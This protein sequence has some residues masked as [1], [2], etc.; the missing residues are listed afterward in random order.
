MLPHLLGEAL[1]LPLTGLGIRHGLSVAVP[2]S[3]RAGKVPPNVKA[4]GAQ[5]QLPLVPGLSKRALL[6]TWVKSREER[7]VYAGGGL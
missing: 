5:A 6:A 1:K 4:L 3:P 7:P 2:A